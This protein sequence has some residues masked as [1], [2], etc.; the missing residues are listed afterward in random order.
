MNGMKQACVVVLLV[1]VGASIS[2]AQQDTRVQGGRALDVNPQV[3]SGGT[4]A[5]TTGYDSL[6]SQLYVTGQ[7]TG[8]SGFRGNV[9]YTASDQLSL[10]LPGQ[11][12]RTFRQQSVG[13]SQVAR[14]Q[15]FRTQA[16]LDRS[17]TVMKVRGI[18]SGA[19]APG[20]N[21]P[22]TSTLKPRVANELFSQATRPY[23]G[24]IESPSP[25]VSTAM[26]PV[27]QRTLAPTWITTEQRIQDRFEDVERPGAT[28]LFGLAEVDDREQLIRQLQ[29][30][31]EDQ[32]E[33]DEVDDPRLDTRVDT[34]VEAETWA[35]GELPPIDLDDD[36]RKARADLPQPGQDIFHDL[37]MALRQRRLAETRRGRAD[38][39]EEPVDPDAPELEGVDVEIRK[40]LVLLYTLGGEYP[41]YFNEFMREGDRMLKSGRYYDAVQEYQAA[42]RVNPQNPLARIGAA[43]ALFGAGENYSAASQL[44]RAFELFPPLME[45]K[46]DIPAMMHLATFRQRLLGLK[47]DLKENALL[48][49]RPSPLLLAAYLHQSIGEDAEAHNYALRLRAVGRG[50][51]LYE[52]Y[53]RFLL[54]DKRPADVDA[55]AD[56]TEG[57]SE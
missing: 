36:A 41:D 11:S 54:E 1:A 23:V 10:T 9:P 20:T 8:L 49:D 28:A 22:L 3:G 31:R 29:Q 18:T 19:A 56:P 45:T 50:N 46:L 7:V 21:V 55:A 44:R 17:Q 25:I 40:D 43:L 27:G 35:E 15:T 38:A 6:N 33:E 32:D 26:Q 37:L 30:L 24:M 12:V 2:L 14:G 47:K 4:N 48:A 57:D 5:P 52:A 16:Y 13:V 39:A 34:S 51:E 53:A 42:V